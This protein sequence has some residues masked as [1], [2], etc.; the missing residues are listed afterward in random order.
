MNLNLTSLKDEEII[1]KEYL[2][3]V[4][5]FVKIDKSNYSIIKERLSNIKIEEIWF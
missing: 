3:E 5:Y 2:D 1:S 4:K